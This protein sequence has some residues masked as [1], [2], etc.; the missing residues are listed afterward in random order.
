A[1]MSGSGNGAE[2]APMDKTPPE[3][4]AAPEPAPP[5]PPPSRKPEMDA[6]AGGAAVSRRAPEP[7]PPPPAPAAKAQPPPEP[8]AAEKTCANCGASNPPAA[9]FCFDRGTPFAKKAEAPSPEPVR[10]PPAP[11][12]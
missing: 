12:M 5:P 7:L 8:A 3:A 11:G 10:P 6:A 4:Y 9:K 2:E 1:G